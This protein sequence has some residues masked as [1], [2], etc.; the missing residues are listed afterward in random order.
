[1]ADPKNIPNREMMAGIARYFGA[2]EAPPIVRDY[3]HPATGLVGPQGDAAD[4][5]LRLMQIEMERRNALWN[6]QHGVPNEW[7]DQYQASPWLYV[8]K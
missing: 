2:Q 8:G 4:A 3:S 6:A 1:M 5:K 7:S